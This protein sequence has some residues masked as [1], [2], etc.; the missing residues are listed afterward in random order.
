[1]LDG[2][3]NAPMPLYRRFDFLMIVVQLFFSF[4]IVARLIHATQI[5]QMNAGKYRCDPPT[6]PP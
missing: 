2:F 3:A 6:R 5:G 4:I 1:M